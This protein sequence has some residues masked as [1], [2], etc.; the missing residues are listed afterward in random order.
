VTKPWLDSFATACVDASFKSEGFTVPAPTMLWLSGSAY[1]VPKLDAAQQQHRGYAQVALVGPA[2]TR[3]AETGSASTS[4]TGPGELAVT[5]TLHDGSGHAFVLQPLTTY[6]LV[7]EVSTRLN[8]TGAAE[9][10]TG[11]LDWLG[12][13]APE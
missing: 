7:T 2:G 6:K 13:A 9:L 11:R 4:F 8:C 1:Y 10:W 3:L 5:G 12:F